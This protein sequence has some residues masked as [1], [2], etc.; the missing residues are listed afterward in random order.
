MPPSCLPH[1]WWLHYMHA[2]GGTEGRGRMDSFL[3]WPS[4]PSFLSSDNIPAASAPSQ[5]G[6]LVSWDQPR[7]HQNTSPAQGQQP[8]RLTWPGFSNIWAT[9]LMT[10][11]L[12][13]ETRE[14]IIICCSTVFQG[15][16]VL[17]CASLQLFPETEIVGKLV[18][19]F[20]HQ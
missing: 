15:T 13:S 3:A 10:L 6:S 8:R 19:T 9:Y 18:K 12:C 4:F 7:S 17:F 20:S 16:Q 1:M 11:K 2:W 14:K 5:A